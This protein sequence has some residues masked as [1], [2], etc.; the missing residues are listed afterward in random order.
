MGCTKNYHPDGEHSDDDQ[1]IGEDVAENPSEYYEQYYREMERL[2][3]YDHPN[4]SKELNVHKFKL[5]ANGFMYTTN[6]DEVECVFCRVTMKDFSV[7][8]FDIKSRHRLLSSECGFASGYNSANIPI[9]KEEKKEYCLKLI[10]I[11]DQTAIDDILKNYHGRLQKTAC[12]FTY[13]SYESRLKSFTSSYSKENFQTPELLARAGFLY[14]KE[15]DTV[16]CYWCRSVFNKW[17]PDD[18]PWNEHAK[19]APH[20]GFLRPAL[21]AREEYNWA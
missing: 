11:E 6:N 9:T 8:E 7:C 20:C 14:V 16:Q 17:L 1:D 19:L 4:W 2:K 13:A 5:A 12:L 3:T 21:R 10:E 15:P 18:N